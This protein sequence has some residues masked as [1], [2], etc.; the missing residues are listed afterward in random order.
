MPEIIERSIEET[1]RLESFIKSEEAIENENNNQE[2]I[3]SYEKEL[4]DEVNEEEFGN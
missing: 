4:E 3:S 1:P 2:D